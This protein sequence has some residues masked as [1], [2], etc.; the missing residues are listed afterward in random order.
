MARA[1]I[2]QL[3]SVIKRYK[4]LKAESR[5]LKANLERLR[6]VTGIFV[7]F[8]GIECAGKSTQQK[9]LCDY[10]E[11]K[12]VEFLSTGEPG[13]TDIGKSIR[14]IWK[15]NKFSNM[16]PKTELFLLA[17]ARHQHIVE[18]IKPALG[19]GFIVITDRFFDSTFAYQAYGRGLDMNLIKKINHIS[20]EGLVPDLTF[21]LDI[22]PEKSLE[23]LK[24]RTVKTSKG[25][26]RKVGLDRIE[27]EKL[28]FFQR[29]RNGYLILMKEEP[30]RFKLIDGEKDIEEIHLDI[31][32]YLE[33]FLKQKDFE[34]K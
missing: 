21:L 29:V 3:S 19:K 1:I 25:R 31:I 27:N 4:E 33:E 22:F 8:E 14:N 32:N 10:L 2:G 9:K 23:R 13:G 16:S 5:R 30:Q 24:H 6:N 34:L 7:S 20:T 15:A 11:N 12:K 18:K 28:D 17:A 26:N